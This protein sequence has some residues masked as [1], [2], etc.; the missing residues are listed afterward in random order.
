M[1][2]AGPLPT[3]ATDMPVAAAAGR[4]RTQPPK[5]RSTIAISICL[6]VTGS[7]LSAS[8]QASSQGAGQSMPVNSGKLF[9]SCSRSAASRKRPVRT[10]S[11]QSGTRFPSG[12]PEWQNGT[13]QP[14]HRV[15]CSRTSPSP[16]GVAWWRWS[17]MRSCAGR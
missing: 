12:Q 10:S 9:V 13:P 4:G 16:A 8:T 5:A 11:F 17:W 6:I 1:R 7:S 15:A 14:M 3:I 2:P